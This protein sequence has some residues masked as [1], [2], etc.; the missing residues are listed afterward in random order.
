LQFPVFFDR[1]R[2][3][4]VCSAS[5]DE[6]PA[7]L[8]RLIADLLLRL[9]IKYL[10]EMRRDLPYAVRRT[11]TLAERACSSRWPRMR[12]SNAAM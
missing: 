1:F 3:A 2:I 10:N 12:G 6:P 9:P 4:G 11:K 7:G 5:S 8:V